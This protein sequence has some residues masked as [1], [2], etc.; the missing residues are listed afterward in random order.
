MVGRRI[1]QMVF[2]EVDPMENGDYARDGKYQ[3]E[4]RLEETKR[5]WTP[6]SMKPKLYLDREVVNI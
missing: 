6:D 4:T 5:L 2:F 1:A 3:Q